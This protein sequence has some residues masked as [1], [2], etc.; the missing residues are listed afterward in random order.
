[1]ARRPERALAFSAVIVLA[2]SSVTTKS[3][4]RQRTP[5]AEAASAVER[6]RKQFGESCGFCH[7]LDA[8][9]GRGP[10]LVRSA[11]VAHDTNGDKIG[12]V[13]RTGR[14]DKGM[15]PQSLS[16]QQVSDIAAYLHFRLAESI[17]SADVPAAYP[18]ARLLTGNA[19][20]GKAYFNGAGRCADCH[21]PSG[22][23]AHIA[24]KYSS[25]ELASRMLYPD[26]PR[27]NCTVTLA[28]GEQI[29]GTVKHIDE[30][31][32]IMKDSSGSFRAFSRDQVKVALRDELAAHRALLDQITPAEFHDLFA[33]IASLK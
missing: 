7:G 2:A 27:V 26:P 13:I 33:Y 8:T 6:G 9:G 4:P 15:P 5:L 17:E 32:L 12:E 11:L 19:G 20:A 25:I 28:N 22:D 18:V 31:V 10:D 16:N 29:K 23:L 30:F 1:M 24:G 3:Q 21:S 14:P